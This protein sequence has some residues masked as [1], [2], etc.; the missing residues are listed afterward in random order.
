[1][2]CTACNQPLSVIYAIVDTTYTDKN[3]VIDND[4]KVQEN[5]EYDEK[6]K[7]ELDDIEYEESKAE[8]LKPFNETEQETINN[9]VRN[10]Q[11]IIP[12]IAEQSEEEEHKEAEESQDEDSQEILQFMFGDVSTEQ[13]SLIPSKLNGNENNINIHEDAMETDSPKK[14]DKLEDNKRKS[15]DLSNQINTTKDTRVS[16][17]ESLKMM[18]NVE[19]KMDLKNEDIVKQFIYHQAKMTESYHQILALQQAYNHSNM[20]LGVLMMQLLNNQNNDKN[21]NHE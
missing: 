14:R 1:M 11:P 5:D 18:G 3:I 7:V 17:M 13:R 2:N 10:N 19:L 20:Q 12:N 9:E 8:E 6:F 21:D 16:M 15:L 4:A